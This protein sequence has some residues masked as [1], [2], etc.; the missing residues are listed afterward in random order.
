MAHHPTKIPHALR[1][2]IFLLRLVLGVNFFYFGWSALSDPAEARKFS[3]LAFGGLYTWLSDAN[4]NL[5]TI[6][7]WGLVVIGAC[8]ILGLF[9]RLASFAGIGLLLASYLPAVNTAAL[10]ATVLVNDEAIAVLCLLILI[11]SNAGAYL[12]I[13]KLFH[14][15]FA[16]QHKEK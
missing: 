2:F 16:G 5:R 15:H 10:S 1:F 13:D 14:F 12:G 3:T 11:F 9:T 4:G 8:L 6:F 7:C